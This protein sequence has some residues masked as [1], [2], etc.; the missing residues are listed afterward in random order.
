MYRTS[1]ALALSLAALAPATLIAGAAEANPVKI[2]V[3]IAQYSGP[4]TF[5]AMY[6]TDKSGNFVSTV[7]VAGDRTRYWRHLRTWFAATGG[8]GADGVTGASVGSGRTLT[9]TPDIAASMIDAGYVLHIDAAAEGVG[10][11]PDEI[12]MPLTTAGAAKPMAGNGFIAN[13]Q[14]GL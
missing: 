7:W 5:L 10:E 2:S 1:T 3:T 14:Y 12:Q 6:L 4:N 13:F 9:I 8:Q 11:S